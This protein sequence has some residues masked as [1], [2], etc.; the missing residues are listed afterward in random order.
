MTRIDTVLVPRLPDDA[1]PDSFSINTQTGAW[2]DFITRNR[3]GSLSWFSTT[4]RIHH[5]EK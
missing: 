5:A 3:S 4:R 1:R 2:A